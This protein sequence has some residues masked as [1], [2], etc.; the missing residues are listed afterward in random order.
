MLYRW[1]RLGH[2]VLPFHDTSVVQHHKVTDV[3]RLCIRP[4]SG[5]VSAYFRS[6]PFEWVA[7]NVLLQGSLRA[8]IRDAI[9]RYSRKFQSKFVPVCGQSEALERFTNSIWQGFE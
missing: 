3:V 7:V 2:G 8:D 5:Q 9:P 4:V 1:N 6:D